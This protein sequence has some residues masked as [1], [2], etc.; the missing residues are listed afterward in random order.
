VARALI[1]QRRDPFILLKLIGLVMPLRAASGRAKARPDLTQHGEE[2]FP[3]TAK[4][5]G[6]GA[7]AS[8]RRAPAA[9]DAASGRLRIPAHLR[10]AA[11]S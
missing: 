9:A 11:L 10:A 5:H 2:A 7:R 4:A 3:A 6:D 8:C 1:L